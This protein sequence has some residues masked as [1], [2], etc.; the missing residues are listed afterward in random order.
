MVIIKQE[1]EREMIEYFVG[2]FIGLGILF[3]T[4]GFFCLFDWY[5]TFKEWNYENSI[6]AWVLGLTLLGLGTSVLLL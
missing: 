5:R 2:M 4:V 6:V 3:I 1:R